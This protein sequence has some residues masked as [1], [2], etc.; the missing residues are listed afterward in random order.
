[1]HEVA[2]VAE[3]ARLMGQAQAGDRDAYRE[4]LQRLVPMLHRFIGRQLR[5]RSDVEEVVQDTLL[6]VHA[7]RHTCD[8]ARPFLPWLIAIARRRVID[9][10]RRQRRSSAQEVDI[11]AFAETFSADAANLGE[12]D[13]SPRAL[14]EAID[15]LPD[16]QRQAVTLLKL[17]EMSLKEAAVASGFTVAALKVATHRAIK[18]LRLKLLGKPSE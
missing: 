17:Q 2:A 6:T 18:R 9:R 14:Q 15:A 5:N 1:L 10:M 8:P 7:A 16:V 11:A 4:L 13:W 12:G 3:L